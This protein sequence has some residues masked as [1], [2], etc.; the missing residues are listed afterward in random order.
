MLTTSQLGSALAVFLLT[1]ALGAGTR[2]VSRAAPESGLSG[3]A[4][5][6]QAQNYE[7]VITDARCGAKHSAVFGDTAAD[8]TLRCVRAGEQFLLVDG[9]SS[10]LLEGDSQALKQAAGQRVKVAGTLNGGKISVTS[11]V[12]L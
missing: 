9:N 6:L 12:T 8:C 4:S 2:A 10:Y 11:I 5:S 7:G 3:S 1:G